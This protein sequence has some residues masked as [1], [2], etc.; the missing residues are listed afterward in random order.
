MFLASFSISRADF[1]FCICCSVV[2]MWLEKKHRKQT[3]KLFAKFHRNTQFSATNYTLHLLVI[4]QIFNHDV[5]EY[6]KLAFVRIDKHTYI[7]MQY[8]IHIQPNNSP[9]EHAL[10]AAVVVVVHRFVKVE[11]EGERKAVWVLVSWPVVILWSTIV[12]QGNRI[13]NDCWLSFHCSYVLMYYGEKFNEMAERERR[14]KNCHNGNL[15]FTSFLFVFGWRPSYLGDDFSIWV[16]TLFCKTIF[17]FEHILIR[18]SMINEFYFSQLLS[19]IVV[20]PHE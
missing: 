14:S 10:F 19:L 9:I 13:W 11:S 4:K 7:Q 5:F 17:E 18:H 3:K 2:S 15:L 20:E 1:H 16:N 12:A 8:I 6:K